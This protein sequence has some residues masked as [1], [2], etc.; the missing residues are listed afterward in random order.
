MTNFRSI[1]RAVISQTLGTN[2][3]IPVDGD[4]SVSADNSL[5]RLARKTSRLRFCLVINLN[6]KRSRVC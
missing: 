4:A 5:R 2:F 6:T 3:D 1:F